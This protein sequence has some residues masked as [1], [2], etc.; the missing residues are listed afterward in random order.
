MYDNI[1][2]SH[3]E[4]V[5]L[6]LGGATYHTHHWRNLRIGF[7]GSANPTLHHWHPQTSAP[8]MLNK[9]HLA[10]A[11]MAFSTVLVFNRKDPRTTEKFNL[12]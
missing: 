2:F 12:S 1:G 8:S 5:I 10:P 4:T 7:L 11:L 9:S 6:D 3:I